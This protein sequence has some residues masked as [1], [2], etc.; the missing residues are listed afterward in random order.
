MI[1]VLQEAVGWAGPLRE[2][3]VERRHLDFYRHAVGDTSDEVPPTF[4]ACFLDEPPS[5]PAAASYGSGWLNGGDR[6]E[7]HAPLRA[8][9]VLVSRP[10]FTGV[11]EKSGKA[12]PMALLTFETEFRRPDGELVVKHVGT[13]IRK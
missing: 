5:L 12:G 9:D 1:E 11:V 6:F 13:R 3:V 2:D 4:T 10:R 7:Y 8:G